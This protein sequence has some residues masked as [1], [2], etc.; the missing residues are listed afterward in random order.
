MFSF[1]RMK[2]LP[3]QLYVSNSMAREHQ[4]EST[5]TRRKMNMK[6]RHVTRTWTHLHCGTTTRLLFVLPTWLC[7][8][9]R[10]WQL[11]T[12]KCKIKFRESTLVLLFID[13]NW[14]LKV[15]YCE[16]GG[17]RGGR[18]VI[19]GTVVIILMGNMAELW[20]YVLPGNSTHTSITVSYSNYKFYT[21]ICQC[22]HA[23]M[24]AASL[25]ARG[26]SS[27]FDKAVRQFGN[28]N[29]KMK[30]IHVLSIFVS[31]DVICEWHR[32]QKRVKKNPHT[33]W[34]RPINK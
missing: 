25:I 28:V 34:P 27:F 11:L 5:W 22:S 10:G 9:N 2:L 30:N 26:K 23:E 29:M 18:R 31:S 14:S 24:G 3:F 20:W 19:H 1:E 17:G 8:S 13:C 7:Q 32:H 21:L 15:E 12:L 4:L 16:E 6:S 33:Y